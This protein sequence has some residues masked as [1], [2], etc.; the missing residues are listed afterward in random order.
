MYEACRWMKF[1]I[2]TVVCLIEWRLRRDGQCRVGCGCDVLRSPI[3]K[4]Y[5]FLSHLSPIVGGGT[6]IPLLLYISHVQIVR[7]AM[8]RDRLK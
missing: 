2:Q 3:I 1:V 5:D 4:F 7:P 6:L 8:F